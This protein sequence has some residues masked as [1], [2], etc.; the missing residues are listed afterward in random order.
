MPRKEIC[1][2]ESLTVRF[3]LQEY[4]WLSN[5]ALRTG[6]SKGNF[7]RSLILEKISDSREK[8]SHC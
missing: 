5:E 1:L 4:E 6:R 3:S 2:S 8:H 7:L